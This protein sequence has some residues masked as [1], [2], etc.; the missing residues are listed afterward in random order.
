VAHMP[1]MTENPASVLSTMI[2]EANA[3]SL[4]A[5]DNNEAITVQ[6]NNASISILL[7]FFPNPITP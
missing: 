3:T 7:T 6:S 5:G 1:E 4:G 2:S